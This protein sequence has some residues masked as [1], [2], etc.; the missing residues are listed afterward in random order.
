MATRKSVDV[1]L[2]RA[3][4]RRGLELHKSKIR[5]P[6]AYGYAKWTIIDKASGRVIAENLTIKEAARRVGVTL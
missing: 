5:D 2:R 3:G 6:R 1:R 4:Q